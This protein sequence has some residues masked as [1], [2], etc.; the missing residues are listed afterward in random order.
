MIIQ[1]PLWGQEVPDVS[2]AVVHISENESSY[3]LETILNRAALIEFK[4]SGLTGKSIHTDI[5]ASA[6]EK[7][8]RIEQ[9]IIPYLEQSELRDTDLLLLGIYSLREDF[10]SVRYLLWD[11]RLKTPLSSVDISNNIDLFLDRDV[12]EAVSELLAASSEQITRI[13]AEKTLLSAAEDSSS[14]KE[15][16]SPDTPEITPA[17]SHFSS[18]D[19][20]ENRFTAYLSTLFLFM[21]GRSAEQFPF[22]AQ[23][24]T[25][26]LYKIT[27]SRRATLSLG[28]TSGYLRLIPNESYKGAYVRTLVPIGI[29]ARVT[30]LNQKGPA[31][32]LFFTMGAAVRVDTDDSISHLLSPALPYA[33]S[34]GGLTLLNLGDDAELVAYTTCTALFNI[35]REDGSDSIEMDA[36]FG[37]APGIFANWRF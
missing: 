3:E 16:V 6:A 24:Q 22:G 31:W 20:G 1:I 15:P 30:F 36:L 17:S 10:L 26:F 11:V 29:D 4:K 33:R 23:I 37:I 5:K 25:G 8:P 27:E 7:M 9:M 2:A 32:F 35:Y 13:Y 12:S 34:G 28:I 21:T 19:Q 18:S 14:E